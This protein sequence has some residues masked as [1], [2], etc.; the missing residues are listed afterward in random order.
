MTAGRGALAGWRASLK[1]WQY[2]GRS[3]TTITRPLLNTN[4]AQPEGHRPPA[5]N[6][7][8]RSTV[9]ISWSEECVIAMYG[10]TFGCPASSA[11]ILF[12]S[13]LIEDTSLR[14]LA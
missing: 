4:P 8:T 1:V 5:L 12:T 10:I 9:I 7:I 2:A 3:E 11:A 13:A 14:Y 6:S